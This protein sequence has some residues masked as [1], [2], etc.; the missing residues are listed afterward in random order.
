[1]EAAALPPYGAPGSAHGLKKISWSVL[2]ELIVDH[3]MGKITITAQKIK[4]R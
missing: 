1:M 3:S 2:N 4:I